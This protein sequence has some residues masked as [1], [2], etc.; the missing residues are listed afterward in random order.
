MHMGKLSMVNDLCHELLNGRKTIEESIEDLTRIKAKPSLNKWTF[1]ILYPAI[2]MV[3]CL[4]GFNGT[5]IDAT[6]SFV[7]GIVVG[8]FQ[9]LA[10]NFPITFGYLFEFLSALV[11][12][13]LTN[14]IFKIFANYGMCIQS[15]KIVLSA[16]SILLPVIKVTIDFRGSLSH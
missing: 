10:I 3:L 11:V 14:F 8:I 4:I 1:L 16:L 2:S 7:I 6:L 12:T 15:Q 13:V 5:W 9:V